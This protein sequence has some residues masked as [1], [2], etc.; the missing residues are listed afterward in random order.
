MS[1]P[2][3][4]IGIVIGL[5]AGWVAAWFQV[6]AILEERDERDGDNYDFTE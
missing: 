1:I 2:C 3:I 5:A 6:G 4:L